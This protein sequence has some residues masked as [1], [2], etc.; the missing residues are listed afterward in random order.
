MVM[1]WLTLALF[2]PLMF[3]ASGF[4]DK[5]AVSK[6]VVNGSA[7]AITILSG[8]ACLLCAVVIA[9]LGWHDITSVSSR[10]ALLGLAVGS[11]E[12]VG[13]YFYYKAVKYADASLV[14]ALFQLV[15]VWNYVLALLFLGEQIS[16]LHIIAI[17]LIGVGAAF[18]N[19]QSRKGKLHFSWKVFGPIVGC[20][21]SIA[22]AA[23][24]FKFT[25][26]EG[27][28]MATQFYTYVANGLVG[29]AF[30]LIPRARRPFIKTI[31]TKP[32][33][34]LSVSLLNDG[35]Y[36]LGTMAANFAFLL[37]PVAIVQAVMGVQSFYMVAMGAWL[38][39]FW[40]RIIKENVS[41][42]HVLQKVISI[43][44]MIGGMALLAF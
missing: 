23:V 5:Y 31:I 7:G 37:A 28:F 25:A 27:N 39:R 38:T 10:D 26:L 15:I 30:L 43:A 14:S 13:F 17:G 1:L 44:I 41:R 9:L 34:A 40:P 33:Q 16:Q 35:V 32:W 24:L 42:T 3:A 11:I 19:I 4:I 18:V 22:A 6:I 21:F 8:I 2:A 12:M 29:F 20:T 36:L